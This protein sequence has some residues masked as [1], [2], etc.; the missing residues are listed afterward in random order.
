MATARCV[1]S[2][3]LE[4]VK[5]VSAAEILGKKHR[6]LASRATCHVTRATFFR[7]DDV[8]SGRLLVGRRCVGRSS[9]QIA[10]VRNCVA[11]ARIQFH[12]GAVYATPERRRFVT[13][14]AATVAKRPLIGGRQGRSKGE[15]RGTRGALGPCPPPLNFQTP[16]NRE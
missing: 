14:I 4:R 16:K 1:A 9:G 10:G 3:P 15:E 5:T 2:Y 8:I 7:R 12:Y 11:N 13:V 6:D